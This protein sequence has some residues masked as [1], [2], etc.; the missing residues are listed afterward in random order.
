[1]GAMKKIFVISL[2]VY[3]AVVTLMLWKDFT[4]HAVGGGGGYP[5]GNGD[6]NGD[7]KIDIT[8]GIYILSWLF[9]GGEAP[10]Q[11]TPPPLEIQCSR[12]DSGIHLTWENPAPY[13]TIEIKKNGQPLA[14][15]THLESEYFDSVFQPGETIEYSVRGKISNVVGAA[16][17]CSVEIRQIPVLAGQ[18]LVATNQTS[19]FS[20]WG[21]QIDCSLPYAKGQDAFYHLGCSSEGRF[22]NNGDGTFT[23]RC[24]GL[25]WTK[26]FDM[27]G[28]NNLTTPEDSLNWHN[29]L[30]YIEDLNFA[31]HNDWRMPNAMELLSLLDFSFSQ[32]VCVFPIVNLNNGIGIIWSSTTNTDSG[33]GS[34]AW[35][36]DTGVVSHFVQDDWPSRGIPFVSN[37]KDVIDWYFVMAVRSIDV[38]E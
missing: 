26:R 28:D 3:S 5:V 17:S 18:C 13:D 22:I 6:V 9:T 38:K 16:S 7:G 20:E 1:M 15:L 21:E 33:N 30:R 2:S 11:I 23:D 4:A 19:C 31:G 36:L 14:S 10:A 37:N 29:A 32:Y 35:G 34:S 12:T 8:D 24:T 27:N 25:C